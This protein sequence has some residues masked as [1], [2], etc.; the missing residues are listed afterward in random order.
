M[1]F[2]AK[3]LLFGP[4]SDRLETEALNIELISRIKTIHDLLVELGEKGADW[5]QCLI[6]EKLQITVNR[7][8]ADATTSISNSDEIALISLPGAV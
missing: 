6:P 4:V 2:I 8:F 3:I 7:Q 1:V 5:Q